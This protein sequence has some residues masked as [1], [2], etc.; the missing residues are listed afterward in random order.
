MSKKNL[1]QEHLQEVDSLWTEMKKVIIDT[2]RITKAKPMEKAVNQQNELIANAHNLI[3]Q[4]NVAYAIAVKNDV[5]KAKYQN[6]ISSM[7]VEVGEQSGDIK[8]K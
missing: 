3:K 5:A 1:L 6:Y 8:D 4:K 2:G 7:D